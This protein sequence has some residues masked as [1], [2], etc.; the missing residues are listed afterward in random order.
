MTSTLVPQ[1]Q[2]SCRHQFS[3]HLLPR[4]TRLRSRPPGGRRYPGTQQGCV[5][6]ETVTRRGRTID[7][8][9]VNGSYT[10]RKV[11]RRR[12][13]RQRKRTADEVLRQEYHR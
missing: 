1:R 9:Q 3:L 10:G 11:A 2:V 4:L 5:T 8:S 13:E 12:L 6:R 7:H